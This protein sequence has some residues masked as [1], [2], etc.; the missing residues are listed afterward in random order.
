MPSMK[1]QRV[2]RRRAR[3]SCWR[4][5][6]RAG[7]E[8]RR[9]LLRHARREPSAPTSADERRPSTAPTPRRGRRAAR[10][11]RGEPLPLATSAS[12]SRACM[13]AQRAL[14]QSAHRAASWRS[15]ASTLPPELR[16]AL[17]RVRAATRAAA[18]RERRFAGAAARRRRARARRRASSPARG[19]SPEVVQRVM[20][21]LAR[22]TLAARSEG[23]RAPTGQRSTAPRT[24]AMPSA[25]RAGLRGVACY[26]RRPISPGVRP[27]AT[28][29]SAPD[30]RAPTPMKIHE[31]Q[32]KEILRRFG[33]PVPRG[34]PGLQRAR[35]GRSGAEARRPGLGRQGADPRRR[36]R[37]GRRRQARALARRGE[38][39]RRRDPRHAAQD[40]PD[41][42]RRP[43]G[44]PPADRGRRRHQEGVLRRRP[45]RPRHAEGRDDGLAAKAA[46]TSR[47]WRTTRPR[48]SSRSSSIRWPA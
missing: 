32:G 40:A 23:A 19:F 2:A 46:W 1:P 26:I 16:S 35:G 48:R 5:A 20:R 12:S 41:R 24:L 29:A 39:A 36:P 18:V 30:L 45:D 3:C 11:A 27:R 31:Y 8:L 38:E 44:A 14:R 37:Q 43:E 13:R 4:S 17:A 6:S 34:Y 21:R 9:K 15:T 7:V 22:P 28:P 25:R 10:L 47:R 33:V 42:P